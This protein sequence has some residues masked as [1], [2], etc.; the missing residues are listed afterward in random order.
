MLER[1]K[2]FLEETRHRQSL[3]FWRAH[4]GLV[5]DMP[6]SDLRGLRK[7]ANQA[8]RL[9]DR[10]NHVAVSRLT[11]PVIGS[12]AIRKPPRT[13]WAYRPQ[14]WAGPVY[15]S[16]LAAV[17][18]KQKIGDEVTIF[19]DCNQSE[20]A[21]RQVRNTS[22]EDFAP[23]GLRMDVFNFDGSFLSLAVE[24]PAEAL[25]GLKRS[26]ILRLDMRI[27]SERPQEMF[28]RLNIRH[29]PNTEQIV[30]ELDMG[31]QNFYVEFDLYYTQFN[32]DRGDSMWVDLIF[33]GPSMNE[34]TIRDVTMIR[35]PRASI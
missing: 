24:M 32:E 3:R 26:H 17:G 30:R 9:I 8:R 11:L 22:A 5:Q 12:N 34:V 16:G 27:E 7:K 35:R 23:F 4:S 33:E 19:H 31:G 18:S 10:I 28:A 1:L 14:A 6:L 25:N 21:F 13:E 2:K 15:P 20:L 29:G